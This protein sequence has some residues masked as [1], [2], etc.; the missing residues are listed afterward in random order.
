MKI[1]E[2]RKWFVTVDRE[3][4]WPTVI[5]PTYTKMR[6]YPE[7]LHFEVN[8]TKGNE[9]TVLGVAAITGYRIRNDGSKGARLGAGNYAP[10]HEEWV[11]E[12]MGRVKEAVT[13]IYE[14]G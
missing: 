1:I 8:L 10:S 14:N 13:E 3:E 9:I 6:A 12:I 11:R 2:Q 7:S 5:N 4:S